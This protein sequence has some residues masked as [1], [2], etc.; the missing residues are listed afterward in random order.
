MDLQQVTNATAAWV[1]AWMYGNA[2][3]KV[4]LLA[5]AS[6][7]RQHADQPRA[8][9]IVERGRAVIANNPFGSVQETFAA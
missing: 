5:L 2:Q 7:G 6:L 9:A 8:L 4:V 1:E 3:P